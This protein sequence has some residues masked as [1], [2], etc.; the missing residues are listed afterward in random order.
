[1][2]LWFSSSCWKRK[3]KY[4]TRWLFSL[5][6]FIF[7]SFSF[8]CLWAA[9]KHFMFNHR[10][11]QTLHYRQRIISSHSKLMIVTI[12]M[13]VIDFQLFFL[14]IDRFLVRREYKTASASNVVWNVNEIE[15]RINNDP[16]ICQW[17]QIILSSL[18]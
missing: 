6:S 5:A 7:R 9:P 1:M 4:E 17:I 13:H 15:Q 12:D 3:M 14:S 16:F 8:V 18:F 2:L 11:F 10:E